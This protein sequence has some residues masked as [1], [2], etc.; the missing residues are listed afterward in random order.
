MKYYKKIK[1]ERGTIA[2]RNIR[3]LALLGIFLIMGV[4]LMAGKLLYTRNNRIYSDFVYSYA[5]LIAAG[6]RTYLAKGVRL[7]ILI[8]IPDV[9]GVHKVIFDCICIYP[10]GH[11]AVCH[12]LPLTLLKGL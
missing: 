6:K 10:I 11:E 5:H 9:S 4:C 8:L 12:N 2:G 1:T 3:S 7:P